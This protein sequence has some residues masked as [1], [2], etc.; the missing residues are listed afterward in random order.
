[1][2]DF[3][4]ETMTA[5]ITARDFGLGNTMTVLVKDVGEPSVIYLTHDQV[6]ELADYLQQALKE[7]VMM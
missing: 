1:M 7:H 3:K 6:Q 4:I 2:T 5:D